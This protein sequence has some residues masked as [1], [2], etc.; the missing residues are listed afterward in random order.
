MSVNEETAQL[1]LDAL[2]WEN[3]EWSE[4]TGWEFDMDEVRKDF[5][6]FCHARGIEEVVKVVKI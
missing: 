1:I 2:A 3:R 5:I 6:R 4:A